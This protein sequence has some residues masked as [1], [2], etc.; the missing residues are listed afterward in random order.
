MQFNATLRE[1]GGV[2]HSW[3]LDTILAH[4]LEL[5]P[6]KVTEHKEHQPFAESAQLL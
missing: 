3:P 1:E 5:P 2:T 6:G 4:M